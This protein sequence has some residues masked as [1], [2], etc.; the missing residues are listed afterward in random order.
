MHHEHSHS[1]DD[2]HDHHDH[3]NHSHAHHHGE[4]DDY[5][6]AF[7]IAILLNASFVA[8]EF[9]YGVVANSTALIADAGHNL[10]DVLG[11]LLA[12]GAAI[13]ARRTPSGRYTFGMRSSSILAALTNAIFLL[14]ACGAI[15]WEAAW[16][17]SQPP[18]VAGLTVALVAAFGFVVNG[19]SA[20]LFMQGGKGD[21]NIR[22]AYLHMAA[23][24]AI[25]LGVAITGIVILFTSWF[26]LDPVVSLIIVA[27]IVVGTWNLLRES[28]QLAL[29][30]VPTHINVS[31]IEQYLRQCNGVADIHDLHIWGMSTTES[32][33]TVH[34]VMAPHT[35]T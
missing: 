26:W 14:I 20:Y 33:L 35:G 7:L 34:L 29:Q 12:W 31:A 5:G 22:G 28:L 2:P 21:L 6:R 24:A 15:A 25:S 11:L 32:A 19:I 27:I 10:S 4:R 18:A 16:R 1:P 30:A 17:F 23:D 9:G 13:L 3:A 8:A